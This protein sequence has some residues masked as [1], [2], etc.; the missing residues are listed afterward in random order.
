M[1]NMQYFAHH[2]L[3]ESESET[4][5]R[6]EVDLEVKGDWK[7]PGMTDNINDAVNY[8]LLYDIVKKVIFGKRFFLLE[9]LAE[10][11]SRQIFR[12][13]NSVN[14]MTISIRKPNAPLKGILDYVEV[15]IERQRN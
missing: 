15:E 7:I 10:E 5:Q 12:S 9:A 4:G 11:I 6:F 8:Q 2:G 13:V 3:L 14:T 1:V